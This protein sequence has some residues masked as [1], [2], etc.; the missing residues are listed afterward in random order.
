MLVSCEGKQAPEEVD[1][2]TL[3]T[4]SSDTLLIINSEN[5]RKTYRF[6]APLMENYEY[7]REPY[8]EFRRGI[9]IE[10]YK[11][12]TE[13]VESTLVADYAIHWAKLDLWEAK[14]N[15]VAVNA[16][17]QILETQQLFWNRRT[18]KVYS[19]VDTKVTQSGDVIVGV[20][21]ESDEKFDDF[22]FRRPRGKVSVDV[23]PTTPSDS[24]AVEMPAEPV[25]PPAVAPAAT[26]VSAPVQMPSPQANP[27]MF[28][29]GN[30]GSRRLPPSG[31]IKP[32]ARVAEPAELQ[33]RTIGGKP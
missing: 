6:Q 23:E 27:E 9:N 24:T 32:E 33:K 1:L 3:V 26:P 10:T 15:V 22:T 17:G 31:T 13:T 2:E 30:A 28:P 20:G 12:S 14:G 21:F 29:S 18:K 19:N 11:D 5:G 8:M 16:K 7:A 4:Q 25:P